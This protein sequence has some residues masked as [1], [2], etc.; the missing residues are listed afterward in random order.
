M[1]IGSLFMMI[2]KIA[3]S[4]SFS[5]LKGCSLYFKRDHTNQKF[6]NQNFFGFVEVDGLK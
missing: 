1:E 2:V 4:E 6:E 5:S 3:D